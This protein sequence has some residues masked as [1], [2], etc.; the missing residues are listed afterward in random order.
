MTRG[1][2]KRFLYW[3]IVLGLALGLSGCFFNLSQE[4]DFKSWYFGEPGMAGALGEKRCDPY[5]DRILGERHPYYLHFRTLEVLYQPQGGIHYPERSTAT[6]LSGQGGQAA[7]ACEMVEE[8]RETFNFNA[9]D[10]GLVDVIIPYRNATAVSDQEDGTHPPPSGSY[11]SSVAYNAGIAAVMKTPVYLVHDVLKTLYIPVAGTYFM[12][13]SDGA[14]TTAPVTEAGQTAT[15]DQETGTSAETPSAKAPDEPQLTDAA[16]EAAVA[17]TSTEALAEEPDSATTAVGEAGSTPSKS[18]VETAPVEPLAAAGEVAPSADQ[19]ARPATENQASPTAAASAAMPATAPPPVAETPLAKDVPVQSADAPAPV[20]AENEGLLQEATTP[21]AGETSTTAGD[22]PKAVSSSGQPE[23]AVGGERTPQTAK[24]QEEDLVE[25]SAAGV[26]A[27]DSGMPSDDHGA[28]R[29][30]TPPAAKD[31]LRSSTESLAPAPAAPAAQ[32]GSAPAGEERPVPLEMASIS[33]SRKSMPSEAPAPAQ[34]EEVDVSRSKLKKQ[35]AFLGFVSQKATVSPGVKAAFEG[36]LWPDL[37]DECS[38]NV[39]LLRQGDARFPESL[40]QLPRDQFGRLNSFAMTTLARYSGINA[41][42]TGSI[43]DV[44]LSNEISGV[45]WYKAPEGNLRVAILVEVYDAET[46]TKL[47]D[48]TLTHKMNVDELEPGSDGRLREEDMAKLR[49]ALGKIAAE[50]SEMV[51][52]VLED[53]PW[54]GYVTGIDGSR[55]TLSAGADTGLVPGNILAVYNSQIIEGLNNQQF[56]LTGERVGRL[57]ITHVYPDHSE[58]HLVE[59][60]HLQDYSV[61]LPEE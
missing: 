32:D 44:R 20:M 42:V 1:S 15:A 57:Q 14:E 61:V 3:G 54:R 38:R 8:G 50:M 26:A 4:K 48:K 27:E 30:T 28:G 53:Q 41:V 37:L 18:A 46:G 34:L 2:G 60:G 47:L 43:I 22:A 45:L 19:S 6:T 31:D 7:Y 21:P 29:E 23:P 49:T 35:V 9:V 58:A 52:N 36:R 12:F 39:H 33:D 17:D 56:F 16:A 51:C 13:R 25:A 5:A 24:I 10:A 40:T 11:A 59:G 55:I